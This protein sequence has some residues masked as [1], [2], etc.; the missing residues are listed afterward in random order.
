MTGPAREQRPAEAYEAFAWAYDDALGR[1]FHAS[2]EP[3][4]ETLIQRHGVP[5]GAHLDLACGTGLTLGH[6]E[7]LGFRTTG[8][9]ASIPMLGLA[10]ARTRR[11][12]GGDLRA[13][14]VRGT[15]EL[16]TCLYDSLNHL[17]HPED[18]VGGLT[19]AARL[20]DEH[21]LFV[22]DVNH[23]DAFVRVWGTADPFESKG[24]DYALTLHTSY[25][26]F[27]R[28]AHARVEGWVRLNGVRTPISEVRTQRCYTR[29]D[30]R[31]ALRRAGLREMEVLEFDPFRE[32]D[33]SKLVW[34]VR[35]GK[36]STRRT[37]RSDVVLR[38]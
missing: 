38:N 21:S 10:R 2:F 35:K 5:A 36:A 27:S 19:E 16:L 32:D 1:T 26:R 31:R 7:R 33:A 34:V 30:L 29:S 25:S 17:V 3:L 13:L 18:L 28:M 24:S 12:I 23:P 20:M 22:F 9:D 8:V 4:L 15:F 6:L 37:G 14:P 11:L